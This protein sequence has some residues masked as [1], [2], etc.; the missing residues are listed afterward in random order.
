MLLSE[1]FLTG[2]S[3]PVRNYP[4]PLES[5]FTCVFYGAPGIVY[6]VKLSFWSTSVFW[7][8]TL[9]PHSDESS[10]NLRC[11]A[12][13]AFGSWYHAH[14]TRASLSYLGKEN[15]VWKKRPLIVIHFVCVCMSCVVSYRDNT[16]NLKL[17]V[18][19]PVFLWRAS[20]SVCYMLFFLVLYFVSFSQFRF[21]GCIPASLP[22]SLRISCSEL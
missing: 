5:R 20:L 21:S 19:T 11:P 13:V 12:T 16:S 7:G 1:P 6:W 14:G 18:L 17:N 9:E 8:G 3:L 2:G 10:G 4:I 22:S 15:R